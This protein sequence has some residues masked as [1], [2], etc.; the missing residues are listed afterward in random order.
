MR[1]FL[2]AA[3]LTLLAPPAAAQSKDTFPLTGEW[4]S[5]SFELKSWGQPV[6]SWNIYPGGVGL[7]TDTVT[8]EGAE[9]GRYDLVWH[10]LNVG[11][12][13]YG[14]LASIIRRLPF[15]A[16]A[17]SA[18]EERATDLPYGTLAV[19]QG[20]TLVTLDFNV[21]CQDAAYQGYVATLK[22]ASDLV[23]A[24]AKASPVV[25]TEQIGLPAAEET[26]PEAR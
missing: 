16:P 3:L 4:D 11:P 1:T 18:C 7:L 19:K 14:K 2:A 12:D 6:V 21:G 15:P 10:Q 26:R 5:V 20:S 23:E 22:Q 25:R 8:P 13:N 9:F 24:W 17:Y